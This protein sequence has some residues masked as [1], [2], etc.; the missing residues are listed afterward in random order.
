MQRVPRVSPFTWRK[1]LLW[2]VKM[3]ILIHFIINIFIASIFLKES[4]E[5]LLIGL[6][7]ILIDIDHPLYLIFARKIY[8]LKEMW[9][10][11]KKESKINR[12]HYYIFHYIEI[13]ILLLFISYF[14]NR[15]LFLIFFGFFLHWVVDAIM[16]K[17]YYKSFKPW[18]KHYSIIGS[19]I[20]S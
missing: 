17:N 19:F 13:I 18:I 20:I 6:G 5:I 4:L 16:Y 10:F 3:N 12:P 9:K 2:K 15:Y 8:N 14:I 7:G 1:N 11:H